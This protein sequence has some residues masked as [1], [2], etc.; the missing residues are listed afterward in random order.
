MQ[1]LARAALACPKR[2]ATAIAGRRLASSDSHAH[3]H[4]EEHDN[5]QYPKEDFS[6]PAWR[7]VILA[8]LL[9]AGFYKY[10]PEPGEDNLLTSYIARYGTPSQVWEKINKQ[11]LYLTQEATETILLFQDAKRPAIHRCRYP[12]LMEQVSPHLQPVGT[13]VDMSNVVVKGERE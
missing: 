4:H 9:V 6:S 2:P 7:G 11:H 10:A 3:E 1:S 13:S 12:Q 5:T 8:S